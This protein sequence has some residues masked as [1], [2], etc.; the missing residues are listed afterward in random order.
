VPD[1]LDREQR[2]AGGPPLDLV[3]ERAR[4]AEVLAHQHGGV[5]RV[6]VPDLEGHRAFGRQ[7]LEVHP[8]GGA[9]E[10]VAHQHQREH[11]DRVLRLVPEQLAHEL[12]R[13]GPEV[14]VVD[15]E[16]HRPVRGEEAEV[17]L[18]QVAA[19]EAGQ[20]PLRLG[21]RER[22]VGG[23]VGV[24]HALGDPR[25]HLVGGEAVRAEVPR[26]HRPQPVARIELRAVLHLEDPRLPAL[27]QAPPEPR[28]EARLARARGSAQDQ[29]LRVAMGD[30]GREPVGEHPALRDPV[31][32]GDL[33]EAPQRQRG[34]LEPPVAATDRPHADAAGGGVE[35]LAARAA[36]AGGAGGR[37]GDRGRVGVVGEDRRPDGVVALEGQQPRRQVGGERPAAGPH[38]L[39]ALPQHVL[40][41]SGHR[42]LRHERAGGG[43]EV[44]PQHLL[45]GSERAVRVRPGDQ[46]PQ[47]HA[48]RVQIGPRPLRAEVAVDLLGRHEPGGP[49]H[50]LRERAVALHAARAHPEVRQDHA[51]LVKQQVPGLHVAVDD[52]AGV[53]VAQPPEAA[54]GHVPQVGPPLQ[55]AIHEAAA[56][57]VLHH[58]VPGACGQVGALG[59]GQPPVVEHPHHV[60]VL[61]LRHEPHLV[62]EQLGAGS[63]AQIDLDGHRQ[64]ERLVAPAPD[65]THPAATDDLLESDRADAG[66]RPGRL[67]RA[68]ARGSD[69]QDFRLGGGDRPLDRVGAGVASG[70]AAEAAHQRAEDAAEP[71]ADGR[72]LL[73]GLGAVHRVLE[74]AVAHPALVVGTPVDVGH[75]AVLVREASWTRPRTAARAHCDL[76]LG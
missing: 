10:A 16:Q 76:L 35:R 61:Q 45:R 69:P 65:H 39:E 51:I 52:A 8:L 28:G 27:V 56:V 6:Q 24:G 3:R 66:H 49:R 14:G 70:G 64:V 67:S 63:A 25:L 29:H 13:L 46:L 37:A 2:V 57:A 72:T 11:G 54:Q 34:R 21:E 47:H 73:R 68:E 41:A 48:Q 38:L 17:P 43:G 15:D 22:Q 59:P 12:E 31:H 4:Q 36:P 9:L 62:E 19:D 55:L 32:E 71:A 1:E 40:E 30:H 23:E 18:E 58:E 75:G 50:R 74:H 20:R 60:R 7:R 5:L 42:D 33:A 53:G 26:Q 44:A